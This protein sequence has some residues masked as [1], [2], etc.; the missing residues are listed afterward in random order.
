MKGLQIVESRKG[1]LRC[2]FVVSDRI[3]VSYDEDGNWH[4]GAMATLVDVVGLFAVYS[5]VGHFK[6]TVDLSFSLF[7]TAKA[8]EEVELEGKVVG[9]KE[10]LAS[11]V[12]EVRKTSNGELIALGKQWMSAHSKRPHS[13]SKL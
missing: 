7:S 4:V 13:S 10:R 6:A 11:V 3:T 1:F 9:E 8:L 5:L 12:I 2:R